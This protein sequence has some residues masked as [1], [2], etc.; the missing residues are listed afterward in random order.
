MGA[1]QIKHAQACL[2]AMEAKANL[3]RQ[4]LKN[5]MRGGHPGLLEQSQRLC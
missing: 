4:L 3:V 1:R 5:M 2:S